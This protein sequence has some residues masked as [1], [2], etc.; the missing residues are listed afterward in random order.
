MQVGCLEYPVTSTI[1]SQPLDWNNAQWLAQQGN[2]AMSPHTKGKEQAPVTLKTSVEKKHQS[3]G[4]GDGEGNSWQ[5]P[6][7]R[8][9]E[10]ANESPGRCSQLPGMGMP[11]MADLRH[12]RRS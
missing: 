9:T 7:Q 11:K 3:L 4:G 1:G 6:A 2:P 8:K 12:L 5:N 10:R